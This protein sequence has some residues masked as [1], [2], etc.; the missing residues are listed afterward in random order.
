LAAATNSTLAEAI[1]AAHTGNRARARD[2]LASLLRAD[3]TNA[4]YWIWMSSVVDSPR[5]AV[6]CLE[7]ALKLDPTNRAALRGLAVL[8]ARKPEARE[9]AAAPK[10]PRRQIASVSTRAA[11][12]GFKI[13][14]R[15]L[16]TGL[17]GLFAVA[18]VAG[19]LLF[20]RNT[21]T[22]Q[23]A[24]TL[25]PATDTLTPTPLESSPTSTAI[26]ISTR[27]LRTPVPTELAGTPLSFFIPE[28]ATATP[29]LGVT[30]HPS[31]EA[32]AAGIQALV[33]GDYA[34]AIDFMDQVIS[35]DPKMPDAYYFKAEA[36]RLS[37]RAGDSIQSYD[38]AILLD[39]DYAPAYL[40]RGQALLQINPD[41]L[42]VDF[43][44]A[45][46]KDP[47]MAQA[48]LAKA[49]FYAS[50]RLWKTMEED[51]RRAIDGGITNPMVYIR[52][53]DAQL[54][55]EEYQ[56]ALESAIEGSANDPGLLEGYLAVG[57][58]Y[59]ELEDFGAAMWPLQTYV[60]YRPDDHRGWTSLGRAQLGVGQLDEASVSLNQAI[61]INDKY[62]PAYLARGF[63][64][65]ARLQ[66]Q[67]ALDDFYRARRY[68]PETF[69]L[70]LGIGE[71]QT[72]LRNYTEALRSLNAAL[73]STNVQRHIA[74]C[75]AARA[76][77]YEETTPP[78]KQDAIL[79]WN[80]VLSL[81]GAPE[82]LKAQ[83]EQHL[84]ELTGKVPTR[85]PTSTSTSTQLPSPTSTPTPTP[86]GLLTPT[87]SFTPAP[88]TESPTPPSGTPQ[89]RPTNTPPFPP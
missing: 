47:M 21:G 25:P 39:T 24:P 37:G 48:Y 68:G 11:S 10:I 50:R 74:E 16:G 87:P 55:R 83:A 41:N 49:D 62:A 58:A 19:V 76:I 77:V 1:A 75:Y 4:E 79:N 22:F 42:P 51:L 32:Y 7:S 13:D 6:Y 89:A 26:P 36:V 61:S 80:W 81:D 15:L 3:S 44:T 52:L 59:I 85:L 46:K 67:D 66:P 35:L 20:A 70:L 78:L 88:P 5:E 57:R 84:Q 65:I 18:V 14:W 69:Q 28:T 31:Y 54:N 43:N 8:G 82:A 27:I 64:E 63:L 17:L 29:V 38:R 34:K 71:A 9:I 30:P 86:G 2:L 73:A 60:A 23:P 72:G 33:S 12:G 53:S 45:I 40:G 56:A